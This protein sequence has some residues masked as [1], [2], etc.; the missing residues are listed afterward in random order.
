MRQGYKFI[1]ESGYEHDDDYL[2]HLFNDIF[3][4]TN[5]TYKL[6][7]TRPDMEAVNE[8]NILD[9][10]NGENKILSF[11]YHMQL[12]VCK[13]NDR[14]NT[15]NDKKADN[16]ES[17]RD[18]W[19]TLINASAYD[20]PNVRQLKADIRTILD[21]D[22]E[23]AQI[24]RDNS[25]E[26][27][28]KVLCLGTE[29]TYVED[30]YVLR[31]IKRYPER[32]TPDKYELEVGTNCGVDSGIA[33]FYRLTGLNREDIRSLYTCV[34]RFI[35]NA[36]DLYNHRLKLRRDRE[37][38]NKKIDGEVLMCM[39]NRFELVTEGEELAGIEY[40]DFRGEK[41][42]KEYNARVWSIDGDAGS[43]DLGSG[44]MLYMDQIYSIDKK[45]PTEEM[46]CMG[47]EEIAEDFCDS[48]L[49]KTVTML[50]DFENMEVYDL[51]EKYGEYIANRYYMYREEHGFEMPEDVFPGEG[52]KPY[53][54][55]V[56]R[57]L[58]SKV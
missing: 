41:L 50:D 40:W 5:D 56:I 51:C 53:V 52:V 11:D 16:E 4:W 37:K 33:Q 1:R 38:H 8:N 45:S 21:S 27:Y 29:E 19:E 12:L 43:I 10:E 14:E 20:F 35:E 49:V 6:C 34:T 7:Y 22:M 17:D 18:E 55:E 30:G 54:E 36:E 44:E 58:K 47:V 9:I 24:V 26:P 46:L 57:L 48:I 39:E 23:D 28:E 31:R 13:R 25:G 42:T 3:C 15:E 32:D 2:S